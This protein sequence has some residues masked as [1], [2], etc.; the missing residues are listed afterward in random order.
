M[1]FLGLFLQVQLT[2]LKRLLSEPGEQS[3]CSETKH[4]SDT[5]GVQWVGRWRRLRAFCT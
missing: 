4:F 3:S 5:S 2:C 1:V